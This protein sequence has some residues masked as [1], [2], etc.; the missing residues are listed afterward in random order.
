MA[1][2]GY[3]PTLGIPLLEGRHFSELDRDY[4]PEVAIVDADWASRFF[5]GEDVVGRRFRHG[6]CT[7]CPWTTVVGVVGSVPYRGLGEDGGGVVY[8]PDPARFSSAPFLFVR[9]RG[10]PGQ[11][12]GA[13][14]AEVSAIDPSTPVTEVA[15]GPSLLSGSLTQPRH[16][17]VLLGTFA[18]VALALATVGLYGITSFFV[19][20]R[21]GDIALRLALGGSPGAILR[22]VVGQG[23]TLAVTGLVVGILASLGLT[24]VLGSLLYGVS[25]RSPLLLT[26]VGVILL[27]VSAVACTVPARRTVSLDPGAALRDE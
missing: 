11:V 26:A 18:L 25:P 22:M 10:E 2:P 9:T 14:R 24:T 13:I 23:M 17:T 7:D 27:T 8:Q 1:D 6:G 21:R 19:E 12:V 20:R 3:F 4:E 15:T 16:L 5:P